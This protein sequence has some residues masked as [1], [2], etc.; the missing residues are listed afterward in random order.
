MAFL[1]KFMSGVQ[2]YVGVMYWT[3]A[4]ASYVA[5]IQMASFCISHTNGMFFCLKD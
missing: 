4:R 5:C 1:Q 2:V 3:S